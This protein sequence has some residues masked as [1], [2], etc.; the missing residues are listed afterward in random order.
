MPSNE[1]LWPDDLKHLQY[2]RKPA[3]Q[4]DKEHTLAT[5]HPNPAP[6]LTPQYD[7]LLPQD[8]VLGPKPRDRS[9]RQD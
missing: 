5:R 2:R 3:I 9:E 7:Q 6:A 1:R 4:L 8:R